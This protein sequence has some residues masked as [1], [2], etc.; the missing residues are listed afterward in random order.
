M[1]SETDDM[2]MGPLLRLGGHSSDSDIKKHILTIKKRSLKESM[3]YFIK[4]EV[5]LT[6]KLNIRR[7]QN[8]QKCK[9][10]LIK[11]LNFIFKA[12]HQLLHGPVPCQ[13]SSLVIFHLR[14]F[15][16]QTRL[17]FAAHCVLSLLL[18]FPLPSSH[19]IF[20]CCS[21]ILYELGESCL[22]SP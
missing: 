15:V 12:L 19:S 17:S 1:L 16:L 18:Q 9:V 22:V 3:V 10:T 4:L 2:G 8:R 14:N 20:F 11:N 13:T 7:K 6:T 5:K 21:Y